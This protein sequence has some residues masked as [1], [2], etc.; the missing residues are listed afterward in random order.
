[1]DH[2][3]LSTQNRLFWLGRYSERVYTTIQFM[4]EKYDKMLDDQDVDYPSFCRRIGIPCTYTD[5]EDFCRGYLFDLASPVS[6]A[7]NIENMLG[8]GM[9]L[10]EIIST[11][12]LAYL[13]MAHNAMEM[14]AESDG[15]GI[16]LQWVLDDIMAF[17]GSMDD[18]VEN[19]KARNVVKTGGLVERLSLMLRLEWHLDNLD[20]ELHKLLNRLY[21]TNLTVNPGALDI[22]T[23]KAIEGKNVDTAV[24]LSSVEGL[25]AV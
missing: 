11:P 17:R 22:I 3:A 19:E 10:R 9:V 13:Q 23:Q 4:L 25:F 7:S 15:P 5:A 24:L 18:S 14:A 6:V 8:N 21:K 2:V 16:Q 1:M 12:T 20:R